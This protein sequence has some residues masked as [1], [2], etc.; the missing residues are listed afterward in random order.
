M[1]KVHQKINELTESMK[2]Y[3][4]TLNL[5]EE[6]L[7]EVQDTIEKFIGGLGYWFDDLLED[8]NR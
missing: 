7:E 4:E 3:T 6:Y 1:D 8:Y 5:D 2:E